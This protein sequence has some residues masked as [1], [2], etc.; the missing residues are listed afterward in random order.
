MTQPVP[1]P[2]PKDEDDLWWLN[3]PCVRSQP[4]PLRC[5][6]HH[7]HCLGCDQPFKE[8]CVDY[9]TSSHYCGTCT[10]VE[11]YLRAKHDRLLKKTWLA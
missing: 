1:P 3:A 4:D 8:G 7:Y 5:R 11:D 10:E 9:N 2:D 6:P